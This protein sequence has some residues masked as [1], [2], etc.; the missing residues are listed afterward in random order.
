MGR[1]ELDPHRPARYP[2]RGA[3]AEG[4]LLPDKNWTYISCSTSDGTY[5][6]C[7]FR[8][9]HGDESR[10]KL[11]ANQIGHPAA[12]PEVSTERTSYAAVATDYV[13]SFILAWQQGN[14]HRMNRFASST[15]VNNF[16]N[17]S[18]PGSWSAQDDGTTDGRIKITVYPGSG[19]TLRF[20]L[21]AD[22]L[23][24]PEAIQAVS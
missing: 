20:E 19:P 6:E 9:L 22:R 21:I 12:V 14:L 18:A 15:V 3:A 2:A 13:S 7:L 11:T 24:K 5:H 23:G 4:Q 10:L 1:E 17:K 8:N 16:K